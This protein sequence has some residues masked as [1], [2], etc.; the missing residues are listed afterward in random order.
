[1]TTQTHQDIIVAGVGGQGILTICGII[2]VAALAN[3]LRVK[4]SEVHGMAQRG[5][6]VVSHVRLSTQP[7]ASDLIPYGSAHIILSM[8]PMEALRYLPY[9]RRD[10][11]LIASR[12]PIRNLAGYPDENGIEARLKEWPHT[13]ILDAEKLARQ[14]GSARAVNSV[15]LGAAAAFLMIA[16]AE[17]RACVERFFERKG[18]DI[19]DKNLTAFDLGRAAAKR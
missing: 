7:I 8:E 15:I 2:G 19:V 5:G 16:E 11:M 6:A 1:M 4:Q 14:A 18:R 13:L 3:G 9:A 10:A 12:N 17:L